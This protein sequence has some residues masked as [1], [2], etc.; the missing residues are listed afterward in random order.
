MNNPLCIVVFPIY[1]SLTRRE[2]LFFRQAVEM[3]S[4]FRQVFVSPE[5]FELDE[6]F[7][8]LRDLNVERFNDKYFQGIAGYN[9]LMLSVEFYERFQEYEYILIHQSDAYLFKP[10]LEYWCMQGYDY[11]GA[12]W[13]KPT[14]RIIIVFDKLLL[15]WAPLFLTAKK[16][17]R[18]ARYDSVGNGGLSLR[19]TK[20]FIEILKHSEAEVQSYL[21]NR[22][23]LFNEDMF[24]SI[25]A[26][27]IN[28]NFSKPTWKEALRFAFE[29]Y[30]KHAYEEIGQQLPFGCHASDVHGR[31]FWK[32]FIP[33]EMKRNILIDLRALDNLTCGF[34]QI[35]LNYGHLFGR[36]NLEK[37]NF[38][39]LVPDDFVSY[40]GDVVS[41][42]PESRL[43][44]R[45]LRDRFDLIHI[46]H[47][48][49]KFKKLPE[50]IPTVFTVH[51][52]NFLYEKSS[53]KAEKYLRK[54]RGL[55]RNSKAV[56]TISHFV[57]E[58]VKKSLDLKEK[59]LEVIYN[60]VERIDQNPEKQPPFIKDRTRPFFFTIGQVRQKK[61]F[62]VLLDV[63]KAFPEY[64]LY[65]SGED[66][67]TYAGIIKT[68]I[69]DEQITNVFVTGPVD[70]EERVWLY[71]HCEAFLFPSK[72]EGFGLPVIEA[73]QFGKAVFSSPM[74]SLTEI[75]GGYA[76]LW[77]DDFDT[78]K[79]I[80]VIKE[81]LPGF[82]NNKEHIRRMK[83]YAYSFTYERHIREYLRLY[84]E[85]LG[86]PSEEEPSLTY[87]L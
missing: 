54:V 73:M 3:T 82:Y 79:M 77:E 17:R 26:P 76:F 84:E 18:Y 67:R 11:I 43:S 14:R 2:L 46:T 60:G 16:K 13:Y 40:F 74:T 35:A 19:K 20:T 41:Y 57:A 65:I 21:V 61:N 24:W 5:S 42:I 87:S 56:V 22:K 15:K 34:G 86:I 51:D 6:S 58:E 39:F 52:L 62:H 36:L 81:N 47:Q 64:D 31:S 78:Q 9:C 4:S 72:F 50:N 38:T 55:A 53:L 29:A 70:N 27:K 49:S 71:R 10:E 32:Q 63:M 48:Q 85:C 8:E 45:A 69:V 1:R 30:P 28:A 7:C 75:C 59:R 68:R 25:Q 37:I 66:Q 80:N 83:E 12:P 33:V 23:H 44:I